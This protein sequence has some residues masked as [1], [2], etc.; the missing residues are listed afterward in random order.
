MI[1]SSSLLSDIGYS[2]AAFFDYMNA[3]TGSTRIRYLIYYMAYYL[4]N[5][6]MIG[7]WYAYFSQRQVWYYLPALLVITV[8]QLGG[9]I[10]LQI[11]LYCFSSS[12]YS[13]WIGGLCATPKEPSN[14]SLVDTHTITIHSEETRPRGNRKYMAAKQSSSVLTNSHEIVHGS[15]FSGG[16]AGNIQ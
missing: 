3:N 6:C 12:P 10:L 8:A 16:V 11:Y 2:Y 7:A 9:F 15:H 14:P 5:A 4:E 13:T 1:F